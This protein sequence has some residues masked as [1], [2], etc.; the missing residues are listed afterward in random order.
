MWF[1]W[2]SEVRH[3]TVNVHHSEMKIHYSLCGIDFGAFAPDKLLESDNEI[4]LPNDEQL[5]KD[6]IMARH[7]RTDRYLER[8]LDEGSA[9]QSELVK[10]MPDQDAS[11][12]REYSPYWGDKPLF[13]AVTVKE[14]KFVV[15]PCGYLAEK[16]FQ[17]PKPDSTILDN[18]KVSW[19]I[20][21]YLEFNAKGVPEHVFL[22]ETSGDTKI[23]SVVLRELYKSRLTS[24]GE[25][26]GGRV[27]VNWGEG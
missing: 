25:E 7:R 5:D 4:V 21:A 1:L 12:K 10:L 8:Q 3:K 23:D 20:T 22:V 15:E 18:F 11:L 6:L 16:G 24:T 14:M 17:I 26:T 2:P 27:T 9:S 19:Q 13:D